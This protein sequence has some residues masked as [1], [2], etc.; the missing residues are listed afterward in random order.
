MNK[1]IELILSQVES[2][3]DAGYYY[4]A[5]L[6]SLTL[7]DICGA[8]DSHDGQASGEKYVAWFDQWVVPQFSETVRSAMPG[9]T[10]L[11]VPDWAFPLTGEVCYRFR[12]SLLHQGSSQHPKSPFRRIL[13]VVPGTDG[14][15]HHCLSDDAYIL[16]LRLFCRE[17]VEGVRQWLSQVE[18]NVRFERNYTKFAHLH[19]NGLS[20]YIRGWPVVG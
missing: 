16:D 11:D 5:L 10:P 1:G 4:P 2:A 14:C 7:P 18:R 17:I 15:V 20:P 19:P 9:A 12:C 13:A 3:L 8:L 6:T